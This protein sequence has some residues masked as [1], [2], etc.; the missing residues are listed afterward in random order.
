MERLSA[1]SNC[2]K[3]FEIVGLQF[4]T[5]NSGD[6][7]TTGQQSTCFKLLIAAA[8]ML[9]LPGLVVNL[10]TSFIDPKVEKSTISVMVEIVIDISM[11]IA[12]LLTP[13]LSVLKNSQLEKFFLNVQKISEICALEL[14]FNV[15]YQNLKRS[16]KKFVMAFVSFYV[17]FIFTM[18]VDFK[19]SQ[20]IFDLFMSII[21]VITIFYVHLIVLRFNFYAQLVNFLLNI[22]KLL[23]VENLSKENGKTLQVITVTKNIDELQ[24]IIILRK[25][26]ILIREM[27]QILSEV[28]GLPI[29]FELT[30]ATTSLTSHL[31]KFALIIVGVSDFAILR[32]L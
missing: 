14:Y 16:L 21:G 11:T 12:V 27:A 31:F 23:V 1:L 5:L 18:I 19:S 3:I 15:N 17:F 13:V 26:Y 10:L 2:F 6:K 32:K 8:W 20:T 22:L 28:M 30:V 9:I 24:K 29:L 4:F 25:I 7:L